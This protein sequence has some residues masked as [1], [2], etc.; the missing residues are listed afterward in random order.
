MNIYEKPMK[1]AVELADCLGG[2]TYEKAAIPGDDFHQHFELSAAAVKL[3]DDM[4]RRRDAE[5][6]RLIAVGF[7][8]DVCENIVNELPAVKSV[9]SDG[10]TVCMC[11]ACEKEIE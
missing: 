11:A 10:K 1:L 8:C 5:N 2:I 9:K 4:V 6:A 3:A 7:W